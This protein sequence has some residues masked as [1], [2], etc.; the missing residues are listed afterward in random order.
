MHIIDQPRNCEVGGSPQRQFRMAWILLKDLMYIRVVVQY[1]MSTILLHIHI[2]E[3][4]GDSFA[5]IDIMM[6]AS[7]KSSNS[8]RIS[9]P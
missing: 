3:L 5:Q 4:Q 2:E 1:D 8:F 6:L 7:T 9:S